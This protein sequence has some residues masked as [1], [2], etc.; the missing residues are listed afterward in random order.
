MDRVEV[1]L[2][3]EGMLFA[4]LFFVFILMTTFTL[5]NLIVGV[6]VEVVSLTSL[7][8]KENMDVNFVKH[9]FKNLVTV[10]D[11]NGDK[12]ISKEDFKTLMHL[13]EAL[14]ALNSVG[15][16]V[17]GLVDLADFIF[18]D[19]KGMPLRDF[20]ELVLQLRG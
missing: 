10:S 12:H 4:V 19:I 15:V 14:R 13:P 8:E 9:Y 7:V 17:I 1:T 11:I 18:K 20:M 16:D 3:G 6:L 5:M 2:A